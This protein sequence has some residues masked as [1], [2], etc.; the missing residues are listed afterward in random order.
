TRPGLVHAAIRRGDYTTALRRGPRLPATL[1]DGWLRDVLEEILGGR[2]LVEKPPDE[3][4]GAPE[5]L[6][7]EDLLERPF[8]QVE[9]DRIPRRRD[10]VFRVA[11]EAHAPE[12][13]AGVARRVVDRPENL[14]VA[15]DP[16]DCVGLLELVVEALARPDVVVLEVDHRDPRVRP[17]HAVLG[18]IALKEIE[19]DHPVELAVE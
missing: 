13:G 5:R 11:L 18:P 12:V 2:R 6:Q 19:L 8:L 4:L 15:G 14:V 1:D 9:E 3:R 10:D 17:A 16:L 7:H